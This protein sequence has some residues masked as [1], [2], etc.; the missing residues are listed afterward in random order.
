V[1]CADLRGADLTLANLQAAD[2][3]HARFWRVALGDIGEQHQDLWRLADL[4][5]A[6]G[7][8]GNVD[9]LL[10]QVTEEVPD[11]ATRTRVIARL[12]ATLRSE[13]STPVPAKDA[14]P[15]A[16]GWA[17]TRDAVPSPEQYEEQLAD[18]L[19]DLACGDGASP[20]LARVPAWR[21]ID[22]P[23]RPFARRL[24]MRLTAD[25]CTGAQ[26]LSV[27]LRMSL[28]RLAQAD[29]RPMPDKPASQP[30][31]PCG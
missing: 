13:D 3:R 18:F 6:H 9:D 16:L 12:D 29:L 24:A 11:Q 20:F 5:G 8:P 2:L 27:D 30:P 14:F 31:A 10:A 26:A 17:D 7:I 15:Q 22:E 21:A 23:T 1:Q 25:R 19:G 4:R 28:R